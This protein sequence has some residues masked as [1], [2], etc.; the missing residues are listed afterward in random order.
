M[1]I[2]QSR[3]RLAA[4][5]ILIMS[6]LLM[7]IPARPLQAAAAEDTESLDLHREGTLSIRFVD[8]KNGKPFSFGTKVGVFRTADISLE[9]GLQFVYDELFESAGKPP[10]QNSQYTDSLADRLE[11][12]AIFKGISLEVPSQVIREDGTVNFS[13]LT[14]GLFLIFQMSGGTDSPR[15]Q[16]RPFIV[17]L[18]VQDA[19]GSF[20]YDVE[21]EYRSRDHGEGTALLVREG[22]T[23]IDSASIP[24]PQKKETSRW[25]V[26]AICLAG[27]IVLGLLLTRLRG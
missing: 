17:T 9:N 11:E 15:F 7:L 25:P 18:P 21:M 6:I 26:L 14:P 3:A 8:G 19:D 16:V 10:T 5:G 13:G 27:G 4:V 20:V 22:Q 23:M 24:P 12:V 2:D 1:R